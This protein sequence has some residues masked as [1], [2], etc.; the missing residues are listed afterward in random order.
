MGQR[1]NAVLL[2][3]V[4]ELPTMA[5]RQTARDALLTMCETIFTSDEPELDA[6]ILNK[7]IHQI[8]SRALRRPVK[9]H[10]CPVITGSAGGGKT[11]FVISFCSPLQEL[12]S[13]PMLVTDVVDRRSAEAYR[14]P[15]IFLDDLAHLSPEH[16]ETLNSLITG[17]SL[18][19]RRL[20]TGK[21]SLI[22]QRSTLIATSNRSVKHPHS[23]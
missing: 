18:A 20:G 15:A 17:E 12:L 3:L 13:P 14:F 1:R 5:D 19:R 11:T 21:V 8:K 23:G 6:A 7:F 9:N 10:L 4:K 22:A 2:P 16:F